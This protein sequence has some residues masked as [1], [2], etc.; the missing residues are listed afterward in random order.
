MAL[1]VAHSWPPRNEELQQSTTM[2]PEAPKTHPFSEIGLKNIPAHLEELSWALPPA[3]VH[4]EE[5]NV[6]QDHLKT[7]ACA[8]PGF[9]VQMSFVI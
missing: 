2:E 8:L 5:K 6:I 7:Q 3:Q 4:G 9:G 1:N